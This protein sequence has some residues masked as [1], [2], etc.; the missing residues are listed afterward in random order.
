MFLL[1]TSLQE[2]SLAQLRMIME[3]QQYT[4]LRFTDGRSMYAYYDLSWLKDDLRRILQYRIPIIHMATEPM[5]AAELAE[6]VFQITMLNIDRKRLP[7]NAYVKS[8]YAS[9]W[10]GT[11]GYLY[12]K[13]QVVEQLIKFDKTSILY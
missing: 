3:A 9:L 7:V 4:S 13:E 2:A 10:N 12:S 5:T 11:N 1:R 8:K 6:K